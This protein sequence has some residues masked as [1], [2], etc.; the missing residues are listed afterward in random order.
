MKRVQK[1]TS[2]SKAAIA[3]GDAKENSGGGKKDG[4]KYKSGRALHQLQQQHQ[5]AQQLM[6]SPG[7]GGDFGNERGNSPP[8]GNLPLTCFNYGLQRHISANCPKTKK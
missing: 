4:G 2:A 8:N 5:Q 3:P 1:L 7:F 6:F